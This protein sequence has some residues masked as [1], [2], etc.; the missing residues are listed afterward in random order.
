[1]TD[2]AG[3]TGREGL[4]RGGKVR[5]HVQAFADD[6][7]RAT[8]AQ[9]FGTYPGHSPSIDRAL[10]IFTPLNSRALG[11]AICEFAVANLDHYGVDYIIYRRRIYNPEISRS[12]RPMADRGSPTQ[13]HDDHV[14]VSFGATAPPSP[15]PGPAPDADPLRLSGQLVV[16]F[17]GD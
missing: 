5:P 7:A 6:C 3:A 2:V 10:D 16:A 11:D 1:V 14:H 13:N 17:E 15:T 8:G 9:S 4:V 12:W